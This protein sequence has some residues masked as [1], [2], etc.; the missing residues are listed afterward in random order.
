MKVTKEAVAK[1]N[2]EMKSWAQVA[3]SNIARGDQTVTE[4]LGQEKKEETT[5]VREEAKVF[6]ENLNAAITATP[7]FG[8]A[9]NRAISMV[10]LGAPPSALVAFFLMVGA[11]LQEVSSES[12]TSVVTSPDTVTV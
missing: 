5:P 11:R 9:M 4:L 2:E 8:E 12:Q 7:E 6:L 1:V 3:A 10:L